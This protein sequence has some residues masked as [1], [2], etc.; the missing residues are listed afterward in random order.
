MGATVSSDNDSG[1]NENHGPSNSSGDSQ[2]WAQLLSPMKRGPHAHLQ[3][4]HATV[5]SL[6]DGEH[7]GHGAQGR[8]GI[9]TLGPKSRV[10]RKLCHS[11]MM[12]NFLE[13]SAES[14]ALTPNELTALLLSSPLDTLT[15]TEKETIKDE[16]AVCVDRIEGL[17]H[18]CK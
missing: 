11:K 10:L 14:F 2:H 7:H 16:I 1:G 4:Y 13:S 9:M 5:G 18:P 15:V 6:T 12:I 17:E 3:E 8:P